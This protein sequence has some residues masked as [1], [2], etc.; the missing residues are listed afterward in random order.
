MF[1]FGNSANADAGMANSISMKWQDAADLYFFVNGVQATATFSSSLPTNIWIFVAMAYDGSKI[2][3]YEG[4]D[5]NSATL[6]ST[7]ATANQTV[8]LN[9]AASLFLG[10]SPARDRCFAGWIDD[11]RFYTG[12]GDSSFVESVRQA[13]AGPSGLADV[14]ANSQITLTW[15]PFFSATSYNVKRSTTSGGAY[16]AISTPGT[17]TGTSYTDS[18]ALNGTFYYYVVSAA[19]SISQASETA[20]SATEVAITPAVP[21][22]PPVPAGLTATGGNGQV[23]LS[24][25]LEWSSQL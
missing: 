18:T 20:N 19:T 3:L 7:T 13:A 5:Q 16:T 22:P 24:G 8:P 9:S 15:N 17:V 1:I 6:I 11:F 14:A 21:P 2:N 23:A 12:A 10:N 25:T 4:T